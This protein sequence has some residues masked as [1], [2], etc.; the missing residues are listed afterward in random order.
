MTDV[1][2]MRNLLVVMFFFILTACADFNAT[3]RSSG[4]YHRVK[5][6][7]TLSKIAHAYKVDIYGLARANNIKD[8]EFVETGRAL[9]I[10]DAREVIEDASLVKA[11]AEVRKNPPPR[12]HFKKE[13]AAVKPPLP[14]EADSS[15]PFVKDNPSSP[16]PEK[17]PPPPFSADTK[18]KTLIPLQLPLASAPL[19]EP[20]KDVQLSR[21]AAPDVRRREEKHFF[22]PVSGKVASRFGKQKNGMFNNGI[23]IVAAENAPVVA[24]AAGTVIFAAF[25]KDYGE[26]VIIKHG[27]GYATVYA[28]LGR[29]LVECDAQLKRGEKIAVLLRTEG[30]GE[31]SL[32]FE[33]RHKN[34]ARNPLPLLP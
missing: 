26:T 27:N 16:V 20:A 7:E 23:S 12:E 2:G 31:P 8:I 33:I 18:Q 25:L 3:S 11:P 24:A 28:H 1:R 4:V 13:M 5:K 32:H 10:P 6:G 9:F 22:W 17:P 29:R 30:K 19:P 34:K 15:K 14:V 21:A